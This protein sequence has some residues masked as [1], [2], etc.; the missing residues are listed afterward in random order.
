MRRDDRQII[1]IIRQGLQSADG[2][3]KGKLLCPERRTGLLIML[4]ALNI[5]EIEAFYSRH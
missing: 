4:Q 2:R 1:A 3:R 5:P